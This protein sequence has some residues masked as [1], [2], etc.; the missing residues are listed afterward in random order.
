V[1]SSAGDHLGPELL[2][3]GAGAPERLPGGVSKSV[4]CRIVW[5]SAITRFLRHGESGFVYYTSAPADEPAGD[6]RRGQPG[7][8]VERGGADLSPVQSHGQVPA[9][10]GPPD[11]YK[12]LQSNNEQLFQQPQTRLLPITQ[13]T[14]RYA[15]PLRATKKLKT[16]DALH[17]ATALRAGCALLLTNDTGFRFV[18]GLPLVILDDLL[19]P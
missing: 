4:G 18:A 8:A 19:S 17:A 7:A 13:D 14:L 9:A 3:Q 11:E 5:K 16:P 10:A 1:T 12:R 2:G 15:A 6:R